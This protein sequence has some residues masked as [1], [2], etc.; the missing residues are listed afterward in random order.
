M[1]DFWQ[2][3]LEVMADHFAAICR[4]DFC[5]RSYWDKVLALAKSEPEIYS[6]LPDMVTARV[7]QL[8][9]ETNQPTGEPNAI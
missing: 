3:H 2:A 7:K 5:K 1:T 8:Q 4:I 9:S 6:S